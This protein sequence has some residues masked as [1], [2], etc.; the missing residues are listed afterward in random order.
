METVITCPLKS[1]C[2]EVKRNKMYRCAWY[3][4]VAGVDAQGKDTNE[5]KC[6]MTWQPI[7]QLE[8]AQTNRQTASSVQSM[9]NANDKRQAQAI[10][11]LQEADSVR[12]A[13]N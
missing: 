1:K 2:E 3:I 4:E 6:A 13:K 7:L 8:V 10:S 5:S 11:A 12:I 9:R